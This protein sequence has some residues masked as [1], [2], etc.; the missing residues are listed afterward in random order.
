[1]QRR[2]IQTE[3]RAWTKSLGQKGRENR[4]RWNQREKPCVCSTG[5][6]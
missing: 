3:R 5:N 1:M 6:M 2:D 4:M